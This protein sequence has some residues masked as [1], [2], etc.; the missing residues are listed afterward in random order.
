MKKKGDIIELVKKYILLIVGL[1]IMA[2]GVAFSIKAN[3]GTTPIFS[4]PYVISLFSPLTVGNIIILMHC[5]FIAL[6]IVILRKDYAPIQLLQLPAAILFGYLTDF[7]I[8]AIENIA[9]TS[10]IQQWLLCTMGIGLVGIGCSLEV[11]AN[12]VTLAAEGFI[13]AICKVTGIKFGNMKVLFDISLVV[14]A[15][16][17][18]LCFLGG[19]E[20]VREGTVA[21]AVFVGIIAREVN[22]LFRHIQKIRSPEQNEATPAQ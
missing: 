20:G 1:T 12:V 10:Y 4:V 16:I 19:I 5:V 7:A 21:A 22:K 17:L 3:I 18:S 6:Q 2:F 8:F 13:L 9:Y 15:C 14:I 11:T